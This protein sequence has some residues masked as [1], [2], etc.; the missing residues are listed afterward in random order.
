VQRTATW[1]VLG[2]TSLRSSRRFGTNSS[3]KEVTPVM[4]PAGRA[5]LDT[6]PARTGS[7]LIA[8]TIGTR[9]VAAFAANAAASPSATM[10]STLA[11]TSS[12]TRPAS[13]SSFP[14][15]DRVRSVMFAAVIPPI[16][17]RWTRKRLANS[18]CRYELE[19]R[20]PM[21]GF[22]GCCARAGADRVA[23]HSGRA[24]RRTVKVTRDLPRLTAGL[25]SPRAPAS[26]AE[27]EWCAFSVRRGGGSMGDLPRRDAEHAP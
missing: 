19:M 20:Y 14:A 26:V 15:A 4:L 17:V 22:A 5:R 7:P 11:L 18:G 21:R 23:R 12:M 9:R 3:E 2:A 13:R 6:R 8:M 24:S 16:G 27:E 1:V 25:I 10:T